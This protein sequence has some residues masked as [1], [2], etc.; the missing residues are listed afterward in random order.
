MTIAGAAQA[1]FLAGFMGSGKSTIGRAV[2]E[3]LGWAFAD[4]DDEIERSAGLP[5]AEIFAR[6]GEEGFRNREHAALREQAEQALAG[7]RFVLALGGGTYAFARNRDLLREAGPTIWLDADAGTLW[8][9][10]RDSS[11][12]PLARDR[13]AFLGLLETRR[14]SYA[15]ADARVDCSAEP[16]EVADA[17][18]SLRWFQGQLG[19][20]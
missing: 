7:R 17:V 15:M 9:R 19:D 6:H 18:L 4:L 5:I 2:A 10:V 1:I 3:R 16:S 11:H 20:A 8:D 14:S 13:D 12:R